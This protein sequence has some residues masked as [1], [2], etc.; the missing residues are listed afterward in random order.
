ML[1]QR[2]RPMPLTRKVRPVCPLWKRMLC[3]C[4]L[5][6]ATNAADR[7]RSSMNPHVLFPC[8]SLR[9][10][11]WPP[12]RLPLTPRPL[13]TLRQPVAGL[14]PLRPDPKV[15]PRRVCCRLRA[16][17]VLSTATTPT[18]TARTG[19][20]VLRL[21]PH[22]RCGSFR[23]PILLRHPRPARIVPVRRIAPAAMTARPVPLVPAAPAATAPAPVVL[24]AIVPPV[25]V[26]LAPPAAT[27]LPVPVVLAAIVL[28]VPVVPAARPC[29]A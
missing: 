22:P 5:K 15:P 17:G 23:V 1:R 16:K 8:R 12:P 6:I 13:L 2:C 19:G 3:A 14:R 11:L 28:P 9:S 24:A 25:P 21:R 27:V 7:R 26:G 20:G 18:A 10:R 29:P 4:G